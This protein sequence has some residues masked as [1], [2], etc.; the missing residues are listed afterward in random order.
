MADAKYYELYRRSSLGGALTDTLDNLITERR[1]EPQLAM[2]I[3]ANFDKAVAE[4]LADK[5][6]SRLTFKGHL[7]TYR[8]CDDVW[9]FIIKD[10]NFKLDNT[11]T[12]HADRVKIVSCSSK[13][14][15]ARM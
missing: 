1:I 13:E 15:Q 7:D 5:V 3:L 9:T 8:F 14:Q 10:I 6:K 11:N 12:I 4:V 2:K